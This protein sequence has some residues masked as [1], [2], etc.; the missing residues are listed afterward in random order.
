MPSSI[1]SIFV[2][3]GCTPVGVV[4][5]GERVPMTEPGVYVVSLTRD[6]DALAAD[7]PVAP[8][9]MAAVQ[10]L[11]DRR[12]E[13]LLDGRRPT[14]AELA[15]RLAR[16]WLPDEV[17][18]YIGLAGTSLQK[19]VRQYYTTPLGAAR[20][21]SGGWFLKTLGIFDDLYV[22]FAPSPDPT[23]TEHAMLGA[24]S[25]A[26]STRARDALHDRER[27]IPFAN[28][29]WPRGRSKGH[30]IVGAREPKGSL[31]V[32]ATAPRPV[33]SEGAR[34]KSDPSQVV[35]A[36]HRTQRITDVDIRNGRIRIPVG[37][38]KRLFPP[39]RDVVVVELRGERFS[40]RWDPKYGSDK[41]RSGVVS[42][43]RD[44]AARLLAPE[45]VLE[46]RRVG[47]TITLM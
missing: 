44:R 27:P 22:H 20:P 14:P 31:Q 16:F 18:V 23:A 40:C 25:A 47:D 34:R 46:I 7:M 41:E 8:I 11:L 28:L 21:H 2:A 38:A 39:Q 17:A 3:A 4:R 36:V 29:E 19:R 35:D 30:R 10:E 33:S 26:V 12:P 1:A 42:I 9:S 45:D 6:P 13:L 5:W 37:S 24:F 32:A 15:E 43:G